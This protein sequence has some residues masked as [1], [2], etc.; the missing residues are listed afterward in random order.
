MSSSTDLAMTTF[1]LLSADALYASWR[2]MRNGIVFGNRVRIPYLMQA[3]AY[4]ALYRDE[5]RMLSRLK[6]VIK[7]IFMH[8]RNL[9]Y[10]VL[11][12]KSLNT[13]LRNMG[14]TGGLESWISGAIGGYYAFGESKG[15][16]GSVNYQLC[17]YLFS[18]A[19]EATIVKVAEEG[20]VPFP[21]PRTETGFRY[22][23]AFTLAFAL[24][25]TEYQKGSLRPSFNKVMEFL[26]YDSDRGNLLPPNNFLLFT[27]LVSISLT[28]GWLYKP[29][30]MDVLLNR[31]LK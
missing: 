18:R 4:T 8:G 6:F 5:P 29:L 13:V 25:M 16:S 22:F 24:Y 23:A 3:V 17:L 9:G 10:F 14:I 28:F 27:T 21:S 11:I 1:P 12:Y 26:Y 2:G 15:V 31:F 19:V 7:Q 20:P 30:D